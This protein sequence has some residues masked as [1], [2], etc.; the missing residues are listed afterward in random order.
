[1][2]GPDARFFDSHAVTSGAGLRSSILFQRPFLVFRPYYIGYFNS[3]LIAAKII[4]VKTKAAPQKCSSKTT[5]LMGVF[6][7][8]HTTMSEHS[9]KIFVYSLA[10]AVA[11]YLFFK[12]NGPHGKN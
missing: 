8:S 5:S 10:S 6:F 9:T 7:D 1:M 11:L 2:T 12:P 4:S 3:Q